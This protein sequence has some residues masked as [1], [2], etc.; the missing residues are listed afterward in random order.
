MNNSV[1]LS[2]PSVGMKCH[3]PSRQGVPKT[4]WIKW[5][6]PSPKQLGG[7]EPLIPYNFPSQPNTELP[8]G[9]KCTGS[10]PWQGINLSGLR[11][12]HGDSP[13]WPPLPRLKNMEF[14]WKFRA[15]YLLLVPGNVANQ[16]CRSIQSDPW[17][18][19]DTLW[20]DIRL[21]TQDI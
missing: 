9:N 10:P 6:S 3:P 19:R 16:Y 12:Y 5:W 15:L 13:S 21:G 7:P 11:R 14:N 20:W 1:S 18:G 2:P 4:V 8:L 17:T